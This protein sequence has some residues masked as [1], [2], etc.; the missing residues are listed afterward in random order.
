MQIA[1]NRNKL[2]L[3]VTLS[4]LIG[5]SLY[6]GS[7]S[8]TFAVPGINELPTGGTVVVGSATITNPSTGRMNINQGAT[9]PY[10][11]INWEK[12]N[13]G[14]NAS[15]NITQHQSSDVLVN[16]VV[17]NNLSEI[18]G[19][20]NATGNV[21]LINPNGVLFSGA[22]VNVGGFVASTAKLADETATSFPGFA[23]NGI[24]QGNIDVTN[25]TIKAG[26][27]AVIA[28]TSALSLPSDYAIGLGVF[29]D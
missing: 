11:L 29:N 20:L 23:E 10:A 22:K 24:A 13:I 25:S 8:T 1:K 14:A 18:Y 26:I 2:A 5:T 19:K 15:V 21:V 3:R 12:F 16:N 17:S 6:L 28:N 7:V 9:T 27:G 4:L